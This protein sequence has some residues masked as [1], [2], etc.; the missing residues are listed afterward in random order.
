MRSFFYELL[1]RQL[2]AMADELF[3]LENVQSVFARLF[4]SLKAQSVKTNTQIDDWLLDMVEELATKTDAAKKF[5]EIVDAIFAK[6]ED[7]GVICCDCVDETFEK[8]PEEEKRANV[9]DV[10]AYHFAKYWMKESI[11]F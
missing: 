10:T 11:P 1:K 6:F 5:L 7:A 3:T 4:N 9:R 8:L 2:L